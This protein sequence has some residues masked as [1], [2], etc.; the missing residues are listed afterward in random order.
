[1]QRVKVRVRLIR[2]VKFELQC[3]VVQMAEGM[4][5]DPAPVVRDK[6]R[7]EVKKVTMRSLCVLVLV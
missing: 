5:V 2:T 7:F 6:K 1:M 4:E 3:L